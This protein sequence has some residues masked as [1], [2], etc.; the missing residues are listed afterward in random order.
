MKRFVF[1]FDGQGAFKPGIGRE[2]YNKYSQAREIIDRGCDVL[3]YDIKEYL[4]GEKANQ[5]SSMTSIA[6]PAISLV[7]LAYARILEDM[8]IVCD[9]SLGHSLG[10]ATAIVYCGV[11]DFSDGIRMIKKRGEVMEKGG[12]EGGMMA[13]INIPMD[14]LEKECEQVSKEVNEPVVIANINAPNQIVVSGSKKGLQLIAQFASKNRGKGIPL[15]VGGAWHS[16]Y[17]KD[18]SEEF[19][20]FLDTIEFKNPKRNFYSVVEQ[21]ILNYGD[22]IKDSLKKQMLARV[23]WVRAIENL[24]SSGYDAFLEIGPSRI[25]KDLVNKINPQLFCDS[26]A[27]YTDLEEMKKN[28]K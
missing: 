1:L 9:V 10:E 26:V 2:L 25:L 22:E 19:S 23:D 14:L 6:Q 21:K 20:A 17:L 15:D 13:M 8:E 12:K 7:S 24:K 18:A 5:T 16:P 4:W 3:G 11:T 28:I 27:L